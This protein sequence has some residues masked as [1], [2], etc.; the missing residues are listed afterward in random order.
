MTKIIINLKHD[1][2]E[3][4]VDTLCN[5]LHKLNQVSQMDDFGAYRDIIE[6]IDIIECVEKHRRISP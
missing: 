3:S 5:D 6:C 2:K 1:A 4:R